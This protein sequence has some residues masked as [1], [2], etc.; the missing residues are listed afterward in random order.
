MG[1]MPR[2]VQCAIYADNLVLRCS[3]EY[4]T[5]AQVHM[6][7]TLNKI[8]A[9]TKTWLVSVNTT[10]T[11][12][13]VFSL[14]TKKQEA[15]LSMNGQFLAED[16]IPNYLGVTFDRRLTSKQQISKCCSRAMLRLAIM[17]TLQGLTGELI[18]EF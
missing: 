9:W 13:T 11:T 14:Y 12:Y 5:T 7:E 3:E 16:P 1:E 17:N 10:K 4:I 6:Q 18:D 2:K 15:K 8:D